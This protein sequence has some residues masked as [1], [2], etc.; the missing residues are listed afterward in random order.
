MTEM[1]CLEIST[2]DPLK[3]KNGNSILIPSLC[4]DAGPLSPVGK[5]SDC[6]DAFDCRSKGGDHDPGPVPS[7]TFVEIDH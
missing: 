6:R 2:L 5:V 7:H 4:L 1:Q 3:Y